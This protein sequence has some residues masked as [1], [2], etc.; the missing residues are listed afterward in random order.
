MN[1]ITITAQDADAAHTDADAAHSES[2]CHA[3]T[4]PQRGEID[5]RLAA[6]EKIRDVAAAFNLSLAGAHRHM[7]SHIAVE[8]QP[9]PAR[10]PAPARYAGCQVCGAGEDR[11]ASV[12]RGL[13]VG[14][15]DIARVAERFGFADGDVRSHWAHAALTMHP[16]PAA[17]EHVPVEVAPLAAM[18]GAE[19]EEILRGNPMALVRARD[20]ML[21][22]YNAAR[23]AG[24]GA[25]AAIADLEMLAFRSRTRGQS[26]VGQLLVYRAAAHRFAEIAA[27]D[28]RK[29]S[30]RAAQLRQSRFAANAPPAV[31]FDPA[32]FIRDLS[33]RGVTLVPLEGERIA[34]RGALSAQDRARI[35]AHRV[36]I[37][38]F[39]AVTETV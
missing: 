32:G 3:C 22:S 7:R 38:R 20:G 28:P 9:P 17:P 37:A 15:P 31:S 33:G 25:G 11:L 30:G 34:V 23:H 27:E 1:A 8:N 2:R 10:P 39:L 24:D 18:T 36:E 16:A 12:N 35:A 21:A 5:R 29:L 14:V 19:A 13:S 4:S 6:G 26:P